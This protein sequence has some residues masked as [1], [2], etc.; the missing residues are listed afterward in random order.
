MRVALLLCTLAIFSSVVL[1]SA[2]RGSISRRDSMEY[3]FRKSPVYAFLIFALA[4]AVG[5]M[6]ASAQVS[7]GS[8]SGTVLDPSGAAVAGAQVKA[9]NTETSQSFTT[10][11]DATG[12]FKINLVPTGAYKIEVKK[13]SFRTTTMSNV[14]VTVSSD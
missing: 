1:M 12:S 10:T 3:A 11:S 7:K 2:I 4:L 14:G 6:P 9:T 5:I 8:I 13:E